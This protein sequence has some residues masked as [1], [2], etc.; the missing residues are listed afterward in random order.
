M[1]ILT[2]ISVSQEVIKIE[3]DSFLP[4]IADEV[5]PQDI[6]DEESDDGEDD[7]SEEGPANESS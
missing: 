6:L 1:D 2:T 5:V 4:T 3:P 7:G